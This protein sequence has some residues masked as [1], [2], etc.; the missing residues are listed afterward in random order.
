MQTDLDDRYEDA[1]LRVDT[2]LLCPKG[3]E[4]SLVLR[5]L[6]ANGKTVGSIREV[7]AAES[8]RISIGLH[9]TNPKKWTA[10]TPY[11]YQL[12]LSFYATSHETKPLQTIYQR[13]GFRTV[14]LKNGLIAV[15]GQPIL[16]RGVNR[17]DHH[18]Q[19][20]RAVPLSYIK[21]DLLLMKS[22]N[23][24]ALRCAH[25]PSHPE[26]YDLCDEL[27][28][29][30]MDEADLECH[31]FYDAVARPQDIPEAMDYEER[32][33]LAF[34]PAA[35]FTSDNEDWREA[36]LDRMRQVVQRDK[37]HASII[38]W[39]L[40]NEAFY[41]CNHKAMYDYAKSID[42]GRLVH[43]EGDADAVSADMFSYMYTSVEQLVHLANTKEIE[44]GNFKKPIV[45][46][47]YA[48]AMGNGPGGL[49]EYQTAFQEYPRLQGGFVWEWANHGLWK[50]DE[51]QPGFYAYGGDF[52][53]FPNDNTFVM[54]GLCFSDHTPTPGLL[55]FKKVTEP[56]KSWV[57]GRQLVIE[58]RYDF[59]CL[60]HLTATYKIDAV[61]E[62]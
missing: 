22:H 39:S 6:G 10:E 19:L 40:G 1:T 21:Q 58:N 57:D 4:L 3:G 20:G 5:D 33:K 9:V 11:L 14:E 27:G 24:N 15:N 62:E 23:I 47:E 38:I 55:E 60:D 26:L 49:E 59:V 54:D 8:S 46:C 50:E 29:W 61:G 25:Y 13:V 30:V 42:P 18:P 44:D 36:Y 52:G 53:D 32:K 12:E 51:G 43:Y 16:L 35:K 28:L 34:G 41:G 48:H 56:V 17:H 31:G 45:L 7:V 2:E 37:N